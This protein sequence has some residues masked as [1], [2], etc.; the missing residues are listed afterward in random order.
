MLISENIH[1]ISKRIKHGIINKDKDLIQQ[2]VES[3]LKNN[4][5]TLD[6]NIG[7]A[8]G[9]LDD[10]F[11][12]LVET[13]DSKFNINYSFDTTS[14]KHME[15][16][17]SITKTPSESFINSTN[18]DE[19]K[20]IKY[21]AL[22]NKFDCNLIGLTLNSTNGIANNSS[23]RLEEAIKIISIANEIGIEN[24]KI[25]ID[26]LVLPISAAQDQAPVALETIRMIKE[27]F[28][29]EVN[30]IV[31]LSNISNGSNVDMR[32]YFNSAFLALALGSGLDGA[33]V[34]G[35]DAK[36]INTYNIIKNNSINNEIDELY[37]KL[38]TSAKNFEDINDIK[39]NNEDKE[40]K[41]IYKCAQM[42]LNEEIYSH[43]VA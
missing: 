32:S 14:F 34:D 29:N 38:Y 43:S 30:T 23:D 37:Y 3:Q 15:Q 7:P 22:A 1:I 35:T 42:I 33:I 4:I 11:S 13:I 16:G 18:S 27:S 36:I 28:E 2:I 26:P 12:W 17:L 19:E 25:W 39:Y 20:I 9:E 5:T 31:G 24:K 8:K 6:L 10:A 40:Q 21:C 41:I